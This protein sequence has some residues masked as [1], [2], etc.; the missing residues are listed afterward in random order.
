[1]LSFIS[2]IQNAVPPGAPSAGCCFTNGSL[3]LA[4]YQPHKKVPCIHGIGGHLKEGETELEAA[5]RELI[6]ELFEI[7]PA[8]DSL[9]REI[10]LH[11]PPRKVHTIHSYTVHMYTFDDL[12]DMLRRMQ[13]YNLESKLYE[14]F[15]TTVTDLI[16]K[17]NTSNCRMA[18]ISHLTIL[19]FVSHPNDTQLVSPQLLSDIRYMK[20]NNR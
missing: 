3:Y 4:G 20:G 14:S 13:K 18:E 15:P 8:P 19:P 1:M 6:E 5:I 11:F 16:F 12:E 7:H 10:E 9:R 17:R 2:L